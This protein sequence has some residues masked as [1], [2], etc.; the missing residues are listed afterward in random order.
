[1]NILYIP[2]EF[3]DFQSAKKLP[4]PVG[5][6]L[7][8]GFKDIDFTV[9]PSFYN[10]ELWGKYLHQI[11]MG[12][13]FDQIW[14]EVLHSKMSVE[15][16]EFIAS[17][18]PVRVGLML[19]SLTILPE[20]YA[21]DPDGTKN[22]E[23][24]L[25]MK[26]PYLTHVVVADQR[27]L[28]YFK[29]PATFE[30]PSVPENIID[31]NLNKKAMDSDKI[32]FHGENNRWTNLL[33]DRA[34]VNPQAGLERIG[35][36][37]LQYENMTRATFDNMKGKEAIPIGYYKKFYDNWINIRKAMY[38]I[39]MNMLWGIEGYGFLNPPNRNNMVPSSVIEAMAAGKV[40]FSSRMYNGADFLFTNGKDILLY[41]SFEHLLDLIN[42]LSEDDKKDIARNAV[43][44]V[45]ESHTTEKQ[46]ERILKFVEESK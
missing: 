18:A 35:Q 32:I 45:L 29:I 2:L 15:T 36:V 37:P 38:S 5:I 21:I 3:P 26:L 11:V 31:P 7:A 46:V 9:V 34:L 24:N 28:V 41:E 44:T 19:E 20:D 42:L 16:L 33:G 25:K 6:G 10:S 27:D 30:V 13:E 22:R 17:L 8:E 12:Q 14:F 43:N 1:M 4:Y 40:V 23:D 39:Q